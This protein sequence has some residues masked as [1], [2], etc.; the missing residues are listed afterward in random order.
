MV[1]SKYNQ[2][3]KTKSCKKNKVKHLKNK[4]KTL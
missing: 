1:K 4:T 3:Q 2:D